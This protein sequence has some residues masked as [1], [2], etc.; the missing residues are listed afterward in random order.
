M[1]MC[2]HLTGGGDERCRDGFGRADG[3]LGLLGI[4]AAILSG[5]GVLCLVRLLLAGTYCA[6]DREAEGESD[7]PMH[8]SLSHLSL[9]ND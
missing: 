8:V 9:K 1:A 4:F 6:P 5:L 7:L 2:D 3:R